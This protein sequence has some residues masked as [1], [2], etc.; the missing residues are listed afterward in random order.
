[1]NLNELFDHWRH[2]RHGLLSTMDQFSDAD[3]AYEPFAESWTV[4]DLM[5]HIP[6][7]EVGWFQHVAQE[8]LAGW[9]VHAPADYP[10][11]AAI[12]QLLSEAHQETEAYLAEF[13]VGD[14]DRPVITPW[15]ETVTLGWI[16]WHVLEH[17]IH[18][19]GELSLILG[20][21]GREGLDV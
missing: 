8:R 10:T 4:G 18:H 9:P 16:T 1:M 13:G 2:V 3:L 7:T 15:G 21:L 17:E 14:L 5:R 20:L 12:Q 19:R 11:I 6:N